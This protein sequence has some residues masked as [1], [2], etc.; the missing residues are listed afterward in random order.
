MNSGQSAIGAESAYSPKARVLL[1]DDEPE[2]AKTLGMLF[3]RCGYTVEVVT[4]ST[5]CISQLDSFKP[6]VVLLDIAM[7]RISGYS[8][9]KQIRSRSEFDG[10]AIIALSGYCDN[11]HKQWSIDAGCDEHLVKPMQLTEIETVIARQVE[12]RRHQISKAGQ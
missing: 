5:Q 9:A 3:S 2:G 8:L 11:Q 12:R 7:P 6:D 10:V 4:D 1:V